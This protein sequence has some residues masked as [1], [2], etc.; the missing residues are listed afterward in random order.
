MFEKDDEF[1]PSLSKES[2][3]AMLSS[4]AFIHVKVGYNMSSQASVS[5]CVSINLLVHHQ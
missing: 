4:S 1:F 5:V 2:S 3:P